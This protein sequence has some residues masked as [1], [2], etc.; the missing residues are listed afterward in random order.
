LTTVLFRRRAS[1]LVAL[2][3][4]A[5]AAVALAGC[6]GDPD[7][8]EDDARLVGME[9]A[10]EERGRQGSDLYRVPLTI[11]AIHAGTY[12]SGAEFWDI[13]I[14]DGEGIRRVCVRFKSTGGTTWRRCDPDD[15]PPPSAPG[16]EEEPGAPA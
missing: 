8:T 14:V 2:A 1:V 11:G 9:V 5:P 6:A 10:V 3:A 15:A 7:L 16:Y 4:V 13:E 12:P